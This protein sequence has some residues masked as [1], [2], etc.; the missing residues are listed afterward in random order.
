[1]DL[2]WMRAVWTTC[3]PTIWPKADIGAAIGN[4]RFWPKA[5]IRWSANK[6]RFDPK[7]TSCLAQR[8]TFWQSLRP[9]GL[10]QTSHQADRCKSLPH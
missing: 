6:V 7:R 4:V 5:D 3:A 1:M 10:R 9:V 2:P 8:Q